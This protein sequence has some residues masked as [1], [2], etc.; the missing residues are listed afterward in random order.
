MIAD[1]KTIIN[2]LNFLIFKMNQIFV[3][4]N[5]EIKLALSAANL[6]FYRFP[7]NSSTVDHIVDFISIDKKEIDYSE[8]KK[9]HCGGY[10][11]HKPMEYSE[12]SKPYCSNEDCDFNFHLI[13]A[14]KEYES[15]ERYNHDSYDSYC[16]SYEG[17]KSL[18]GFSF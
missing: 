5:K 7:K 2:L 11:W 12:D 4:E 14:V 3:N 6:N 16:N 18:S 8:F 1:I 10:L 9:C 15:I 17:K 13:D